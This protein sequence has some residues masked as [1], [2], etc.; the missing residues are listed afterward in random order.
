MTPRHHTIAS[1]CA[2]AMAILLT[3]CASDTFFHDP[4]EE[5]ALTPA[6][7][8]F[9]ADH[10]QSRG[11]PV[12]SLKQLKDFRADAYLHRGGASQPFFSN[13]KQVPA[14]AAGVYQ[15]DHV[16]LWPTEQGDKM[17]FVA[18]APYDV[19]RN[20]NITEDGEFTY[21]VPDDPLDQCD[22]MFAKATD[23]ECPVRQPGE[24]IGRRAPVPLNFS[25]I[26]TQVRFVFGR[27]TANYWRKLTIHSIRVEN[28]AATGTWTGT[29][30]TGL[31]APTHAYQLDGD[32]STVR[33][34]GTTEKEI[35]SKEYTMFLMPQTLPTGARVVVY[36]SH[37]ASASSDDAVTRD[38]WCLYLDGKK[39]LP[40]HTVNVEI[41]ANYTHDITVCDDAGN[42]I[43]NIHPL[44]PNE[45]HITLQLAR[46]AGAEGAEIIVAKECRSFASV[47][48]QGSRPDT[49]CAG[50]VFTLH[51]DRNTSSSDR[52]IRLVIYPGHEEK[53]TG[54]DHIVVLKQ[55]GQSN[56][57]SFSDAPGYV[58]SIMPWGF[59]WPTPMKAVYT[60]DYPQFVNISYQSFVASNIGQ[61]STKGA[62]DITVDYDVLRGLVRRPN[63]TSNGLAN[64]RAVNT[65]CWLLNPFDVIRYFEGAGLFG[66]SYTLE[67]NGAVYD[68]QGYQNTY[69]PYGEGAVWK[70]LKQNN[71]GLEGGIPHS[72]FVFSHNI[73]TYL[74]AIEELETIADS[75]SGALEAGRT[76]WSSTI[77][78]DGEPWALTINADGTRTR[79][80][81][82]AATGAYVHPVRVVQ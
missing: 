6:V 68:V 75:G 51:I 24:N 82:G 28:V 36:M 33:K 17:S 43:Q 15:S 8:F 70:A 37:L 80:K 45:Q 31:D 56:Y 69:V 30:W 38:T 53:G 61:W 67:I 52:F 19:A 10:G 55:R 35:W 76:Y 48:T 58:D 18:V 29:A 73:H 25:H 5:L 78:N 79:C 57:G 59:N 47:S 63:S 42:P 64:T 21:T 13:K 62:D 46:N 3:A 39:L 40:G 9:L 81:P 72:E 11:I 2:A 1:S 32:T 60:F 74:P 50:N 4:A 26:L 23:V 44:S 22:L 27:N 7:S 65:L 16:Y 54:A 34:W 49:T 14:S 12:D 66:D 71:T 20:L 41:N 77:D